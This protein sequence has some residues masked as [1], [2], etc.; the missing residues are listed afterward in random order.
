[1]CGCTKRSIAGQQRNRRCHLATGR[2]DATP[3]GA[4]RGP[5]SPGQGQTETENRGQGTDP[6][7]EGQNP[8]V[9]ERTPEGEEEERERRTWKGREREPLAPQKGNQGE[10]EKRRGK[11]GTHWPEAVDL[12]PTPKRAR[13]SATKVA[14]ATMVGVGPVGPRRVAID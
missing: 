13:S 2:V 8:L 5:G 6:P 12:T 3:Q 10:R 4:P 7:R 9:R 11:R 1:M 14:G